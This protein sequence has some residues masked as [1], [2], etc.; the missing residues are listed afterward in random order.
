MVLGHCDPD[1]DEA[2]V[3]EIR[4]GVS[5]TLLTRTHVQLAELITQCIPG[6]ELVTFLR[7]G[8]DATA[9]AVRLTRAVTGRSRVLRWGY[10]GWHDWCAPRPAGVPAETQALTARFKYGDLGE[11]EFRL[12]SYAGDVA[13]VIMMPFEV[14]LPP[15]GYL[16]GVR[17]L[18]D[19]YGALFVLDEVR[20]GFRLEIGGAQAHFGVRADLAV[21][22]KAMA[23]GYAV[24]AVSGPAAVMGRVGDVSMSSVFFR[25]SDGMAA[26]VATIERLRTTDA[27]PRL[28]HLGR[29]LM[30]GLTAAAEAAGVPAAAVGAPPMPHL[31][32]AYES[33]AENMS[34]MRILCEE[35]LK[36][37][38]LLH[39]NHHWFVCAAMTDD[40]IDLTISHFGEAFETIHA[41]IE[42]AR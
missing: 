22:S 39:P 38:V 27:I 21:F 14:D 23:N 28:W 20:S 30:A 5:P 26:A 9:A 29:R 16:Q 24:S 4:R 15:D 25:S 7:S 1:V 10:Q 34:A 17:N 3:R 31:R 6:A 2:V 36:H 37:G 41:A 11:L 35:M 42:N 32:F 18:C 33:D 8:S 19:R 40:D 12:K 13:C